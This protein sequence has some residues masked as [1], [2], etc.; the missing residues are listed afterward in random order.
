VNYIELRHYNAPH[1][2]EYYNYGLQDRLVFIE[3]NVLA[4]RFYD[5]FEKM[6]H[7]IDFNRLE[8]SK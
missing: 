5:N 6:D 2:F 1:G 3:S 4:K 7:F 8:N